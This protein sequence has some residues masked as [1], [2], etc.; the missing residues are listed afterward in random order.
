MQVNRIATMMVEVV[1]ADEPASNAAER[2][3]QSEVGF[4][5]VMEHGRVVGIVTDR[6]LVLRVIARGLDAKAVLVKEVMTHAV[7]WIYEDAEIDVAVSLMASK[8]VR[9]LLVKDHSGAPVGILSLDDLAIFTNGDETT[10]RVLQHIAEASPSF[11]AFR[12]F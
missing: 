11:S 1:R 3:R 12:T 6:D 7:H 8:A 9:R 4:L 10:G 2:M 5:P